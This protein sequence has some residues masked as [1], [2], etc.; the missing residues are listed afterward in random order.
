MSRVKVIFGKMCPI[1]TRKHLQ[2]QL[3]LLVKVKR[4]HEAHDM[5]I[6]GTV[7][8]LHAHKHELVNV[9][10]LTLRVCTEEQ[11]VASAKKSDDLRGFL[12]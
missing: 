3:D 10:D 6:Y 4:L 8:S 1:S 11:R 7:C 9:Y 2:T 5:I 12:N